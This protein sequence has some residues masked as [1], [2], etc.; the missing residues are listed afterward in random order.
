M[1]SGEEGELIENACLTNAR[2][3]AAERSTSTRD[4]ASLVDE[5]ELDIVPAYYRL[6]A[7]IVEIL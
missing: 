7:G 1:A 6:D 2:R 4:L 3:V 5:G